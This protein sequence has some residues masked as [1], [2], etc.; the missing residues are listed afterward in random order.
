M[1][2]LN[3][4][5]QLATTYSVIYKQLIIPYHCTIFTTLRRL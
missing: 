3:N 2:Y 4:T 5:D 1:D